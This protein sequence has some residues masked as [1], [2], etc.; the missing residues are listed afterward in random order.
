[1]THISLDEVSSTNTWLAQHAAE[2]PHLTMVTAARQI[3]GRGQRGNS[4]ESEPGANLTFSL[5]IRPEDMPA[6]SQFSISEATAL[7]VTDLLA[8]YGLTA[9]VKW[10]NDI[11]VGDRKICGILIEHA[12]MGTSIMHSIIGVGLNVNQTRFISDAPNP[13]SLL[14]LTVSDFSE[15][16][17][18]S[19][20]SESSEL[21]E[22]SEQSELSEFSD[23][24]DNSDY[25]DNSDS[26]D[27]S[28]SSEKSDNS[29]YSDS[30]RR[31]NLD[32]L[33]TQLASLLEKRLASVSTP[34]DR[35][36]THTAFL[37][38]LYRG[39]GQ[40]YPYRDRATGLTFKAVIADIEP[41]G[42]LHLRLPDGTER[43]YAFKEVEYLLPQ[44]S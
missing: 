23:K 12:V 43:T 3:A 10:P 44:H 16:S 26:S 34:T 25:S 7:A 17:E 31:Y 22:L 40:F 32:Q 20:L 24:S 18:L 33:R 6:R 36:A 37:Q 29:D 38:R 8:T 14:Q 1:M 39:D 19:E 27:S 9:T 11:Y 13:V 30:A 42:L 15:Q 2:L 35:E 28:D 41:I 21:S 4:W 5:L